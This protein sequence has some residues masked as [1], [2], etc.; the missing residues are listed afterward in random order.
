MNSER[1]KIRT[2]RGERPRSFP[3]SFETNGEIKETILEI[4]ASLFQL[5][6]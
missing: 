6:G 4:N 2:K 5:S 1:T 3:W